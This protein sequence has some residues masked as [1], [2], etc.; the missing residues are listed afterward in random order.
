MLFRC[1]LSG[2]LVVA[3]FLLGRRRIIRSGLRLIVILFG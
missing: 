2:I 1:R 3:L